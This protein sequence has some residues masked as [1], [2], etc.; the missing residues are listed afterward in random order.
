MRK[1]RSNIVELSHAPLS[2]K[3]V[4]SLCLCGGSQPTP[5][6][7]QRKKGS[8]SHTRGSVDGRTPSRLASGFKVRLE[9]GSKSARRLTTAMD[10][11]VRA[12]C[13]LTD[14][15]FP[16]VPAIF[17]KSGCVGYPNRRV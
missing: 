15:P 12:D 5:T 16:I 7:Q 10:G 1:T 8:T 3:E 6:K 2:P 13:A 9:G 11:V 17:E 4:K 14:A